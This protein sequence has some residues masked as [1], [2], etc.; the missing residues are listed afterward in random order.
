MQVDWLRGMRDHLAI[1][2]P[3]SIPAQHTHLK[4]ERQRAN[5]AENMRK[6]AMRRH[7]YS[8][9]EAREKIPESAGKRL[10]LPFTT[11]RSASTGQRYRLFIQQRQANISSATDFNGYGL[12]LGGTVP[13]F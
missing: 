10:S 3:A 6:R 1:Y 9:E 2:G 4:V 5:S 11:Q 8:R 12:S 7:G 13:T